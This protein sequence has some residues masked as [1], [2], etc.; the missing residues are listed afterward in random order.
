MTRIHPIPAEAQKVFQGT[1]FSVWQWEQ[2]LYD[3]S[4]STFERVAR[5]DYAYAIGVLPEKKILLVE[6]EQPDRSAVLT[7]AGGGVEAG[8]DPSAAAAREFEEETGF[9]IGRLKPWHTYRP[10]HRLEMAVH[11]FIGQHITNVGAATPEAGE[12]ITLRTFTFD[13]FLELG[14]SDL[15]RDW[16]L[17]I[18]LLEA[19]IDPS[20]RDALRALLY[21]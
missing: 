12:K 19:K 11:A 18:H 14:H 15:L 21:E 1:M 17:R 9:R 6:D 16:L 7:P 20:K 8:E 10:S 13:E 2:E 3:G 4:R 5:P